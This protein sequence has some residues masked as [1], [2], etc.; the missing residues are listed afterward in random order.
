M[1]KGAT[2]Q[3]QGER[4]KPWIKT[5]KTHC[6]LIKLSNNTNIKSK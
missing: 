6:E 4:G 2:R 3:G 1:E 5:T